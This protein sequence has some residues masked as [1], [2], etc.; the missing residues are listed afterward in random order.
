MS[1]RAG[2]TFNLDR[3]PAKAV[4]RIRAPARPRGRAASGERRPRSARCRWGDR[5]APAGARAPPAAPARQRAPLQPP[6]L[7][8][9]VRAPLRTVARE[10]LRDSRRRTD[11]RRETH[12]S[13][14]DSLGARLTGYPCRSMQ[15]QSIYLSTCI[16]HFRCSEHKPTRGLGRR[17]VPATATPALIKV[18]RPEAG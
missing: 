16:P 13:A 14:R 15:Y 17:N 10:K 6:P 5:R 2:E 12:A 4:F 1:K 9:A 11:T 18:C 7:R 8:T 3:A